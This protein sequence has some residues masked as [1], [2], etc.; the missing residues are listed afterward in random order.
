MVSILLDL[1]FSP[2]TTFGLCTTSS[3]PMAQIKQTVSNQK[4]LD[5][6]KFLFSNPN[7]LSAKLLAVMQVIRT[8]HQGKHGKRQKSSFFPNHAPLFAILYGN[9]H[10]SNQDMQ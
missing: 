8:E 5:T 4:R 1:A 6:D 7:P 3:T 9:K 10:A 2:A